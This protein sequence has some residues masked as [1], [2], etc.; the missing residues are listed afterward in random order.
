MPAVAAF[1]SSH[2]FG[3]AARSGAVIE[4]IERLQP[5]TRF[6]L[7]TAVPRWFFGRALPIHHHRIV[8]DIG[9]VQRT[10]FREDLAATA[11]RLAEFYPP[12][13][14]RV[15]RLAALV[16]RLGCRVVLCDIAPLGILVAER[17][18]IPS[19]LIENFTW[20]WIY[21]AY[22]SLRRFR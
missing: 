4:A 7:F 13:P 1:V 18:G 12:S 5:R 14:R 21:R 6:H 16:R 9:L 10:P 20:E 17:A 3:H 22:P 15:G 8:A 2:G 19:V 11:K